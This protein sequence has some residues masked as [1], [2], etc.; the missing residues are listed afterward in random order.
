MMARTADRHG[1]QAVGVPAEEGC[2]PCGCWVVLSLVGWLC[3]GAV[4]WAVRAALR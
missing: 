2:P 1:V 3:I 4:V